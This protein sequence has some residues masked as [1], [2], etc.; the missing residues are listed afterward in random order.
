MLIAIY[1]SIGTAK[2]WN[3]YRDDLHLLLMKYHCKNHYKREEEKIYI[4]KCSIYHVRAL[5]A[6][7]EHGQETNPYAKRPENAEI[8]GRT[9]P[10]NPYYKRNVPER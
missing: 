8:F 9:A 6:R 4:G 3:E 1:A 2:V 5:Y 10:Y 7:R